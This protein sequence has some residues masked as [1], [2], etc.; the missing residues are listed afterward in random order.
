MDFVNFLK[1]DI[2]SLA[3][4]QEVRINLKWSWFHSEALF[5]LRIDH[6]GVNWYCFS[7]EE[8]Q[9]HLTEFI[10]REESQEF[11]GVHYAVDVHH[12]FLHFCSL[13]STLGDHTGKVPEGIRVGNECG[14]CLNILQIVD[15][16]LGLQQLFSFVSGCALDECIE[17]LFSLDDFIGLAILDEFEMCLDLETSNFDLRLV[18]S[19]WLKLALLLSISHR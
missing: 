4:F 2:V 17:C 11:G 5:N 3:H 13:S 6:A 19:L 16:L 9:H 15:D 7:P 12:K 10:K 8:V 14:A 1:G 18:D